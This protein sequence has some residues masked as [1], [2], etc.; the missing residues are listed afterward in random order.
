M[1]TIDIIAVFIV[2]A[3]IWMP[4]AIILVGLARST[5]EREQTQ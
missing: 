2:A 5:R 4:L 1:N 3:P